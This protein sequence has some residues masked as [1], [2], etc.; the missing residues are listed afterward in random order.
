MV[1]GIIFLTNFTDGLAATAG[2]V[3]F[4]DQIKLGS[5]TNAVE[6]Q[7]ITQEIMI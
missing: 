7:N 4:V 1:L 2:R 6:D 3:I 5:T